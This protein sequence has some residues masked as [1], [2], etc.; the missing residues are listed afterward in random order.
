MDDVHRR[1]VA[2]TPSDH[3]PPQADL[4]LSGAKQPS[5]QARRLPSPRLTRCTPREIFARRDDIALAVIAIV[6]PRDPTQLVEAVAGGACAIEHERSGP[7]SESSCR[8]AETWWRGLASATTTDPTAAAAIRLGGSGD[9]F[10]D[11][12]ERASGVTDL[13]PHVQ[14]V[15][16]R[17]IRGASPREIAKELGIA[18]GSVCNRWSHA[19]AMLGVETVSAL[20]PKSARPPRLR[21]AR[22]L[23]V[24]SDATRRAETAQLVGDSGA[25]AFIATSAATARSR[26]SQVAPQVI[27][28]GDRHG[29]QCSAELAA[30]LRARTGASALVLGAV[31]S[32]ERRMCCE[33]GVDGIAESGAAELTSTLPWMVGL[34]R[35]RTGWFRAETA[36]SSA[37]WTSA[38]EIISACAAVLYPRGEL[39]ARE[40]ACL[41]LLLAG[42]DPGGVALIT[43][44]RLESARSLVR[45]VRRKLGIDRNDQLVACIARAIDEVAT[46]HL[47]AEGQTLGARPDR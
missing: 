28:V 13:P 34:A 21:G 42:A 18:Y 4:P 29:A 33:L 31:S 11:E 46:N 10:L 36:P 14:Y 30:E 27:A 9:A 41:R 43:E 47:R 19:L 7:L 1:A 20:L 45:R 24:D 17:R 12:V 5:A 39:T 32:E 40:R 23:L 2:C 16:S 44:T 37:G 26:A 35:A 15:V 8:L 6:E 3:S 25:T 38:E 22:I